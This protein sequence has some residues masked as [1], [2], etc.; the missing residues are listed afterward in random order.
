[1]PAELVY[2]FHGLHPRVDLRCLSVPSRYADADLTS[3]TDATKSQADALL[4]ARELVSRI[5]DGRSASLVLLGS[6]GVGKSHLAA[7]CCHAA[8]LIANARWRM[9]RNQANLDHAKGRLSYRPSAS[10]PPTAARWVNVPSLLVD[11]K[12]EMNLDRDEQQQTT[13]ARALRHDQALVVLDDLGRERISEWTGELVY[14]IVNDRYEAGL[15][16]IA[17]SNLTVEELVTAGYWPAISRLAQDGRLVEIKAPDQR[18][19]RAR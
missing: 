14:V 6:P 13:F 5:I 7:A 15:P 16:T 3:I 8:T 11:V 1:M 17:T 10:Y 18:L 4:G 19:R 12:A 9:D 2:P